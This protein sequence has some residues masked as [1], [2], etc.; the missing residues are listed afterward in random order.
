MN[1]SKRYNRKLTKNGNE[2]HFEKIETRK[3]R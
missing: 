1:Y 2:N 3:L